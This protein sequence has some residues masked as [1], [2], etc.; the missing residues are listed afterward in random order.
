MF[1]CASCRAIP[2]P[3]SSTSGIDFESRREELTD[4]GVAN[5]H[6]GEGESRYE[7]HVA[8]RLDERA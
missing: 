8:Q 7:E 5:W 3:V 6:N 1:A 4:Y 2:N